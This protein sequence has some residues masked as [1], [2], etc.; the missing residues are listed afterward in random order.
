M[1]LRISADALA[2]GEAVRHR[3][4]DGNSVFFNTHP[5]ERERSGRTGRLID[6]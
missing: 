4:P 6:Y 5:T 2:F 3:D 1:Q